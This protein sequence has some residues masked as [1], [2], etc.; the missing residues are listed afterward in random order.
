M[1]VL[2]A[3]SIS[4]ASLCPYVAIHVLAGIHAYIGNLLVSW[5]TEARQ[6]VF[7]ESCTSGNADSD[8]VVYIIDVQRSIR[9]M[10]ANDDT[11]H[12]V[13]LCDVVGWSSCLDL[14]CGAAG[15]QH[16]VL[17][18]HVSAGVLH[19]P[20]GH[21]SNYHHLGDQH[22]SKMDCGI[23][24]AG[25]EFLGI[26]PLHCGLSFSSQKSTSSVPTV[27]VV[28]LHGMACSH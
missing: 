9:H 10:H 16:W 24:S 26:S 11:M 17:P 12:A 20:L 28:H 25:V 7:G 2:H 22:N 14:Q 19:F 1:L 5:L 13:G 18:V 27:A 3:C 23:D 15:W 6:C 8:V 4:L 21:S